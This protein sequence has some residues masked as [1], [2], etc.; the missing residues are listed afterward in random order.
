MFQLSDIK[1]CSEG[2]AVTIASGMSEL[3]K[4]SSLSQ[5]GNSNGGFIATR[6]GSS[7]D[8]LLHDVT[9]GSTASGKNRKVAESVHQIG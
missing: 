7:I 4:I 1:S 8:W 2:S 9:T 3:E 6:K 5:G